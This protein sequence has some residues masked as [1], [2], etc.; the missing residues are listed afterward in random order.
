M[1]SLPSFLSSSCFSAP[2]SVG[3]S[4]PFSIFLAPASA[5]EVAS[6]SCHSLCSCRNTAARQAKRNLIGGAQASS[7][8]LHHSMPGLKDHESAAHLGRST[9]AR[10]SLSAVANLQVAIPCCL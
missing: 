10:A 8:M 2:F 7:P 3:G 1:L 9:C 6:F 5:F 4:L